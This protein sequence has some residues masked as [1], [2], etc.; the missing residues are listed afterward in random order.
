MEKLEPTSKFVWRSEIYTGTKFY[1]S[2]RLRQGLKTYGEFEKQ[3]SL[4]AAPFYK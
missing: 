3:Y 1:F 2:E 4:F